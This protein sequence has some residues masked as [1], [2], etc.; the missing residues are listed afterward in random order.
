MKK[1]FKIILGVVIVIILLG[2][3]SLTLALMNVHF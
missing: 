1:I 3:C 2:G